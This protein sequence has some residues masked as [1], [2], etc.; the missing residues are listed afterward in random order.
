MH[1]IVVVWLPVVADQTKK[2]DF[3]VTASARAYAETGGLR[4]QPARSPDLS[5]LVVTNPTITCSKSL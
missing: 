5:I 4:S 3:K 2:L 1:K